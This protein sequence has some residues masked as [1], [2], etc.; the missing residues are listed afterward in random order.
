MDKRKQNRDAAYQRFIERE[1]RKQEEEENR[2]NKNIFIFSSV[3]LL[4]VALS[5]LL[6]NT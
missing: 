1:L 4:V 5:I 2:R 3:C 6:H